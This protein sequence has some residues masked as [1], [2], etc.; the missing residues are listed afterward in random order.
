LRLPLI[1]IKGAGG[2]N[3]CHPALTKLKILLRIESMPQTDLTVAH[4]GEP[5]RQLPQKFSQKLL[6]RFGQ[7]FFLLFFQLSPI[8]SEFN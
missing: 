1:K 4:S 7:N 6:G 5:A 8:Y 3:C 2:F